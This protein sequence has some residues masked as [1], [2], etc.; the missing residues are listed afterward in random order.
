LPTGTLLPN[1]KVLVAGGGDGN[2]FLA[3]AELYDPASGTWTATG[4]LNTARYFHTATLLPNGKLLVAGGGDGNSVFASAELYDPASGTWST[5][6]S[7]VFGRLVH[8]ATLLPDGRVLIAAGEG[9]SGGLAT[10]ELYYTAQ[11][12]T[13]QPLLNISTR[14]RV[15]TRDQVLIGGF[16]ITGAQN[17]TVLI[18]G[19]GPSLATF[20]IATPLADPTLEL[21]DHT[22]ALITSNDNWRDSQQSQIS[23]TGL[24]PSSDSESVI[25]ATLAPGAYTAVLRG[26]AMTTGTGLVEVYD[27][28]QNANTQITNLSARG[29]VGTGDDV[30]IGGTIFHG[31]P[32]TAYRV[33]VR[34][35]G[36]SLANM[37]VATPLLDPALSLYDANGSIIT[38]DD[39]WKDSQ[40]S[41]IAATGLTPTDDRESAVIV[42]LPAGSYTAIVSGVNGT[43]GVG[44]IEVFN[45]H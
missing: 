41:E 40:E 3:S 23:A 43:T 17:K 27:V 25:L 22:S 38:T 6:G 35:I 36:P 45:L 18:R 16:I 2:S 7:L 39:N 37:G 44:L 4:S 8:T 28:D 10:A 20:G 1:G 11:L 24:A 5:T 34:A 32:G 13:T 26:K 42:T 21:H 19:I 12:D 9:Y 29:F 33:L 31:S 15:S 30:M 14:A